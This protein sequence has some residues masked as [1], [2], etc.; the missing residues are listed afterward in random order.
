M[1]AKSPIFRQWDLAS[2]NT[3]DGV[4]SSATLTGT[5]VLTLGRTEGLSNVIV[6]LAPVSGGNSTGSTIV[7]DDT[8]SGFTLTHN[9]GTRDVIVQVFENQ[10]PFGNPI[11]DVERTTTNAIDVNFAVAPATGTDYRVLILEI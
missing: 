7:G 11:V 6:D 4:V 8:T 1:S 10:A 2:I 9:F 3:N 5:T